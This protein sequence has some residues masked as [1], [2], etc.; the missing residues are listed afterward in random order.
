MQRVIFYNKAQKNGSHKQWL[1]QAYNTNTQAL[2][3]WAEKK[4]AQPRLVSM[5]L[6][7]AAP[8]PARE[9]EA[10][11]GSVWERPNQ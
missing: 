7:P 5:P 4:Q 11:P 9:T 3:W 2:V 10:K 1:E 8:Q 6:V